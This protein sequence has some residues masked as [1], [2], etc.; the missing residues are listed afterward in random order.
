[1]SSCG[2]TNFFVTTKKSMY[3]RDKVNLGFVKIGHLISA[4]MVKVS[5]SAMF[6]S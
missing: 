1:M 6:L 2:I 4:N 5:H 3:R